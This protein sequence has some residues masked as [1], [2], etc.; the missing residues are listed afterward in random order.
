LEHFTKNI[1]SNAK[2]FRLPILSELADKIKK[3]EQEK[4]FS[5]RDSSFI[6]DIQTASTGD[7]CITFQ[8]SAAVFFFFFN[9]TIKADRWSL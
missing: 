4:F 6:H 9:L 7:L 3:K 8:L 2:W 5:M 1:N